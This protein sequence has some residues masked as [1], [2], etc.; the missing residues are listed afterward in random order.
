MR[1]YPMLAMAAFLLA[2]LAVAGCVP[3]TAPE[4]G[5]SD[6]PLPRSLREYQESIDYSCAGDADCVIKDVGN[7]CGAY[8]RCVNADAETSPGLVAGFC[9][10]EGMVSVCGF[11]AIRSCACVSGAC[12]GRQ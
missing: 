12:V 10:T 8:P 9:K 4:D 2:M 3:E 6:R 11:P 5:G 7:C 1:I